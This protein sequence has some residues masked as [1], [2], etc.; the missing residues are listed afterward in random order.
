MPKIDLLFE[1]LREIATG[2]PDE[3]ET[4]IEMVLELLKKMSN[5]SNR[6]HVEI[7]YDGREFHWK[8][9]RANLTA[10]EWTPSHLEKK[11]G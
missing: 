2:S 8:V 6:A 7:D 5:L 10:R 1:L 4:R 9:T 11:H 3:V